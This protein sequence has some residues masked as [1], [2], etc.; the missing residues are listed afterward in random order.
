MHTL[1]KDVDELKV[2]I[3]EAIATID[4]AMLEH[5][6]RELDYRLDVCRVTNVAYIEKIP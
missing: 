1:P 2:R 4:N 5:V 6:W 3:T